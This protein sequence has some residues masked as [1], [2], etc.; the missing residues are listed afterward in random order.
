MA[1]SSPGRRKKL[2]SVDR[3][4]DWKSKRP[5]NPCKST[6]VGGEGGI[7]THGTV[8]R[9]TVFEF[10]DSR[11][12]LCCSV[13]K[14]AFLFGISAPTVLDCVARYRSMSSGWF[15]IWFANISQTNVRLPRQS[16]PAQGSSACD[17]KRTC[18]AHG[19]GAPSAGPGRR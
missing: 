6:G 8:T 17:P 11:V 10:Y 15:A 7:G 16:G 12:G 1:A 9:T 3:L 19:P 5:E 2:V 14:R 4:M 13:A 18:Q